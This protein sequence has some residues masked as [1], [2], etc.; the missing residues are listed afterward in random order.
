MIYVYYKNYLEHN[1]KFK[2]YLVNCAVYKLA[3]HIKRKLTKCNTP[4]AFWYY[5]YCYC[6]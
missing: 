3:L 5:N 4:E 1:A 6:M 2:V